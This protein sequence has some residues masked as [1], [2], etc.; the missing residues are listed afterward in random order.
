MKIVSWNCNGSFRETIK[1][2]LDEDSKTYLD[3]DIYVICEC[4]NPNELLPKYK[5]NDFTRYCSWPLRIIL[6]EEREKYGPM[7]LSLSDY[8]DGIPL[9][10][11]DQKLVHKTLKQNKEFLA[12]YG[13]T[14]KEFTL[15]IVETACDALNYQRLLKGAK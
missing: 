11:K 5:E 9:T 1:F 13:I 3:A 10:E 12:K 2:I 4:E 8:L 15:H 14:K 7:I 6:D